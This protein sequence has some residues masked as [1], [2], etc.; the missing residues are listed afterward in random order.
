MPERTTL[1]I[2]D[3]FNSTLLSD[4]LKRNDN[5]ETDFAMEVGELLLVVQIEP[6]SVSVV[7]ATFPCLHNA[8]QS[9]PSPQYVD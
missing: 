6:G 3:G 4:N 8:D 7:P 1:D 2:D 9:S 5:T